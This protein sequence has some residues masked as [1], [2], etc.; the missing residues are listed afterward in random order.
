MIETS[1]VKGRQVRKGMR[2]TRKS[3]PWGDSPRAEG[4]G[5]VREMGGVGEVGSEK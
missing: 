2:N 4:S 1:R 3:T 5:N